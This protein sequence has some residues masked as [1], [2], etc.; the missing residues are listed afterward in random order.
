MN[1]LLLTHRYPPDGVG[2]VE[3][4]T[5]SLAA[6]LAATG[7]RV[8]V[9]TRRP[10]HLPRRP[11]ATADV[12][13]GV[14]VV[15][16]EG[17]GVRLG[18]PLAGHERTEAILAALLAELK[19]AVVHVNHLLG[20]S[21]RSISLA[22]QAGCG[23]VV[24]V[25]DYFYACPRL[26]LRRTDGQDCDG[27]RRGEECARTCFVH[28][29]CALERWTARA[30][31][32]ADA[33]RTAD[34]VLCPTEEVAA[35]FRLFA[36]GVEVRVLPLSVEMP[37]L[38]R[39]PCAADG[40]RPVRLL[41]IGSIQR[42]KGVHLLIE[43][44]A[45]AR[46]GAVELTVAGPVDDARYAKELR[47]AAGKVP[48]LH[49]EGLKP[50]ERQALA[51]LLSHADAFVFP[52]IAREVFPLAPREALAAGVPIVTSRVGGLD[53]LVVDGQNGLFV[54]PADT[55]GFAETLRRLTD[56][57]GLLECLQ[58]GAAATLVVGTDDHVSRLR[59]LY[60]G[61]AA[62]PRSSGRMRED[63]LFAALEGAWSRRGRRRQFA[64]I[65]L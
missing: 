26:H 57:P 16:I 41:T 17:S 62:S 58:S 5:E 19:P 60:R 33:L 55:K 56:E 42:Q 63:S 65:R 52:S 45:A 31:Y 64:Q 35:F 61:L 12:R 48:G 50:S 30:A 11:R 38:P 6:G 10:T 21:P 24:T 14:R 2:G 37:R 43:A 44:L 23:V 49:L 13:D 53:E 3:R 25:P 29:R 32:F 36:P 4:Y 22:K 28:Q 34:Y 1:V 18:D 51:H 40:L 8:T 27:P 54:E 20:L 47:A 15:C 7:D 46:L 59:E 39:S 9:L